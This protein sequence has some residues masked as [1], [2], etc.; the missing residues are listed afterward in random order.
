MEYD[1]SKYKGLDVEINADGVGVICIDHPPRNIL[2]LGMMKG[3]MELLQLF[4]QDPAVRCVL[5]INKGDIFSGNA[6]DA[7]RELQEESGLSF[8][9]LNEAF[10]KLGGGLVEYIDFY[11]KPTLVAGKG[12]C[13]GGAAAIYEAFDV[14]LAGETFNLYD[15]DVYAGSAANWGMQTLRLPI[16]LG[17]NKLM[18]FVF[19]NEEF[20]ARQLYELGIVSRVVPDDYLEQTALT[21]A[22]KMAKSVPV[23]VKEFKQCVHKVLY[24]DNYQAWRAFEIE[25]AK[26]ANATEESRQATLK[27]AEMDAGGTKKAKFG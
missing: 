13:S 21:L 10:S 8:G 27:A 26:I 19:M 11:P 17:R 15:Y 25:Q 16:W 9:E 6:G 4:E 18:D 2:T 3:M 20:N 7:Y 12:Y 24:N 5:L 22:G 1:F 14:R 23:I